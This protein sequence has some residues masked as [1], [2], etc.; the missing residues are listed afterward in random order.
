MRVIPVIVYADQFLAVFIWH[1]VVTTDLLDHFW[2]TA[3]MGDSRS[4][5]MVERSIGASFELQNYPEERHG[6]FR[7]MLE[8]PTSGGS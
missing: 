3:T 2:I 8:I 4:H 1:G 7:R 5:H 6:E